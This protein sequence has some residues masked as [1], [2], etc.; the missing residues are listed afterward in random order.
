MSNGSAAQ[1]RGR[2]S[3]SSLDDED[4]VRLGE[5]DRQARRD[6]RGDC[7]RDRPARREGSPASVGERAAIAVS[8]ATF[9]LTMQ[10]DQVRV[11]F[12][13]LDGV[14]RLEL[15]GGHDAM[16]ARISPRN[17]CS[18]TLMRCSYF[19]DLARCARGR[20]DVERRRSA[21]GELTLGGPRPSSCAAHCRAR[22]RRHG[23]CRRHLQRL[24]RLVPLDLPR[25]R[26]LVERLFA[27][28]R[29][30]TPAGCLR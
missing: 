5:G 24:A 1:R 27:R 20:C 11:P 17:R 6:R 22:S 15:V 9:V 25:P 28:R 26:D 4:P 3:S 29:P 16:R 13:L 8:S 2:R 21:R 7:R 12:S 19:S 23:E 30:C 18:G 10:V 14:E